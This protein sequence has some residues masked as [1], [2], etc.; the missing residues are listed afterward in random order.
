M[1]LKLQVQFNN[2]NVE[3]TNIEKLVKEDVKSKGVKMTTVDTL[4]VYYKPEDSS[5]YYVAT[6]KTGEVV[7]NDQPLYIG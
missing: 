4:E 1:K 3:T 6:T 2:K 5:V 7:G